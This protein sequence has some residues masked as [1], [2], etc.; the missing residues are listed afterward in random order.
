MT[1]TEIRIR[2]GMKIS[3][4]SS[5]LSFQEIFMNWLNQ[6]RTVRSDLRI[7]FTCMN[8]FFVHSWGKGK[9]YKCN[10]LSFSFACLP[11]S[12]SME[13]HTI[14][15]IKMHLCMPRFWL[16]FVGEF[17]PIPLNPTECCQMA[18]SNAT[19]DFFWS[20][21]KDNVLLISTVFV[22]LSGQ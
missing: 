17:C 14:K 2:K 21:K 18:V 3:N 7:F 15:E 10:L 20:L 19:L 16:P 8:V 1:T 9:R 4:I 22:L 13:N 11:F 6:T 5:H 12:P